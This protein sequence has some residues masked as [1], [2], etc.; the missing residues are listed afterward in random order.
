MHDL[1]NEFRHLMQERTL[2]ASQPGVAQ[3]PADDLAQ[4]VP[5]ALVGRHHVV[6]D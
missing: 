2:E 1:G 5:S 6:M 4:D 3:C